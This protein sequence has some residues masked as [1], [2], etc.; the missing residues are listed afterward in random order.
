MVCSGSIGDLTGHTDCDIDSDGIRDHGN[1]GLSK[2]EAIGRGSDIVVEKEFKTTSK[3][4]DS[5]CVDEFEVCI[6]AQHK[7]SYGT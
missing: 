6:H 2:S 4:G 5:I 3:T 1:R 7:W